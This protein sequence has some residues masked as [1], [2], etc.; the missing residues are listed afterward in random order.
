MS[1]KLTKFELRKIITER[2]LLLKEETDG[3]SFDDRI[4]ND[5]NKELAFRRWVNSTQ[6]KAVFE[7]W[8]NNY[9]EYRDKELGTTIPTGKGNDMKQGNKYVKGAW[10]C[11]VREKNNKTIGQLYIEEV[12]EKDTTSDQ[13]AKGAENLENIKDFEWN[14][15]VPRVKSLCSKGDQLGAEV[16]LLLYAKWNCSKVEGEKVITDTTKW[17]KVKDN[18]SHYLK[19]GTATGE[20][21]GKFR[22]K[23]NPDKNNPNLKSK[24]EK[25]VKYAANRE[26][27]PS[28]NA[29][30][31]AEKNDND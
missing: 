13:I 18:L 6:Y 2:H 16:L 15:I 7:T 21:Y 23:E 11:P 28:V 29:V 10:N 14:D 26:T 17:K 19:V 5:A 8:L 27:P 24:A 25:L 3:N 20:L 22:K 30:D 4:G 12:L 9:D 31:T 1:Y